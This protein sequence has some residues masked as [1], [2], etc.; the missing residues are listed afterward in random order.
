MGPTSVTSGSSASLLMSQKERHSKSES[1]SGTPKQAVMG[2]A[3]SAWFATTGAAPVPP[4][5]LTAPAEDVE[6]VEGVGDA[7]EQT[8]HQAKLPCPPAAGP[9]AAGKG[10]LEGRDEFAVPIKEAR[11]ALEREVGGVAEGVRQWRC[12]R[13][14]DERSAATLLETMRQR[15]PTGHG[16]IVQRVSR[17]SGGSKSHSAIM[18]C[19]EGVAGLGAG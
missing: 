14:A 13:A 2:T 3:E 18:I 10:T 19:A 4:R 12:L 17:S 9:A 5:P 15:L 6:Q 1:T 8:V 7:V 11:S 16:T